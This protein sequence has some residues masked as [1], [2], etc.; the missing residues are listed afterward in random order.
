MNTQFKHELVRNAPVLITAIEEVGQK[1][2]TK[3][4]ARAE[5]GGRFQH[6]FSAESRVSKALAMMPAAELSRRMSG[7]HYFMVNEKLVDFRNGDY[8]GFVH[9][10]ES[11]QKL[12]QVI[13]YLDLTDIKYARNRPFKKSNLMTNELM[14]GAI[15]SDCPIVVP[16]YT[17]E[18]GNFSSQL[19]FRWNPFVKNVESLFQLVR[20]ICS[21][22]IVGLTNFLNTRIPLVNRWEE[23]LDIANK[24]IQN[25]VEAI[26]SRRFAVMCGERASVEEVAQVYNH[27]KRREKLAF[28]EG[29]NTEAERLSRIAAICNPAA[30]LGSIYNEKVFSDQRLAA[31][32]AAHLTTFDTYNMATEIRSHSTENDES[33]DHALDRFSNRILF[34]R[35]DLTTYAQRSNQP[36]LSTFSNP[37]EAF[38]G[39]VH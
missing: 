9:S 8:D 32:H 22:G 30:H 2:K 39:L 25:K 4:S 15:W 31:Q 19:S 14:L 6:T 18:G 35:K 28:K 38:F 16:G 5:I 33:T 34:D 21:N 20:L 37:D 23:H 12:I 36:R 7:G 11:I 10:D 1:G 29:R 26:A 27:A 13:G 24:Q 3:I 17:A